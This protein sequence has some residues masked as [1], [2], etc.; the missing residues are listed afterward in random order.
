MLPFYPKNKTQ[1]SVLAS[2]A[3]TRLDRKKVTLTPKSSSSVIV[4]YPAHES[5]LDGTT[6]ALRCE[7]RG[8]NAMPSDVAISALSIERTESANAVG[9]R[10]SSDEGSTAL[11][12]N[13]FH[14]RCVFK[15]HG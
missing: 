2:L 14:L 7:V 11:P 12:T 4:D 9:V 15:K 13:K 1:Q 10:R 8:V 6:V 3:G 5:A